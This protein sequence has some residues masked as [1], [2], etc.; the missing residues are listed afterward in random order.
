MSDRGFTLVELLVACAVLMVVIA[1]ITTLASPIHHAID[2]SLA[3]GDLVARARM[4]LASVVDDL[5]QAG[6]GVAIG[7]PA[8]TLHDAVPAIVLRRSLDDGTMQAPLT[9]VS[10]TRVLPLAQGVLADAVAEDAVTLPLDPAAPCALQN[11]TCGFSAGNRGV[12]VAALTARDVVVNSADPATSTIALAA[13]VGVAFPR[14]AA[15]I[16]VEQATYGLRAAADGSNRLVRVT[17]GGA[18]QPIADHVVDFELAMAD[19]VAPAS[20]VQRIDVRLRVEAASADLRGPEGA[21]FRR[22]GT[23]RSPRAWVPD[24][25][26][27]TSVALRIK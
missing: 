14:G 12:V 9:A 24:I 21:L 2:R 17:S 7:E 8:G 10:I 3:D 16:G 11:A 4:A 27:R 25:E 22:A 15:V 20:G 13:P 26:V 5:Q 18:E 19:P 6:N 23:T 1:A